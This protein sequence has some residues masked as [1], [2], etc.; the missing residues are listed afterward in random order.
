MKLAIM[1][2]YFFPYIGYFQLI[3]AVE[4]FIVY[5]NIKFSK[6]GWFHRNRIL[7]NKLEKMISLSLRKDSDYLDVRE[8]YLADN[9]GEQLA[10]VL[11]IIKQS[12]AKAPFFYE[13]YPLIE[14]VLTF[15]ENNLFSFVYNSIIKVK[16]Y[17]DIDTEMIISSTIPINH[18][19][20]KG[21]AKVIELVRHFNSEEYI[22]AIGGRSL[23]SAEEFGKNGIMIKFINSDPIVYQQFSNEF[24]PGLSIIDVMM[25]NSPLVIRGFLDMYKLI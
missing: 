10:R 18:R 6:R 11:R 23:Y 7:V 9:K 24:V 15:S 1:Q 16:N 22:N 4:K 25:F 2:P 8:R 3:H 13:V 19:E 17:L 5:D 12:Y 14:E 20:L 21:Q